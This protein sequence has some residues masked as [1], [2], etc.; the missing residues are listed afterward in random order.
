MTEQKLG[1]FE[2]WGVSKPA[3]GQVYQTYV[4]D[5]RLVAVRIGGQMDGGRAM[6]AHFGLLGALVGY[7]LQ[8][9]VQKKRAALRQAN[10]DRSLDELLLQDPKN[11]EVR[12][13][14]LE[15]AELKKGGFFKGG[16]VSLFC[17]PVGQKPIELRFQTKDAV[18]AARPVLEQA[19]PSLQTDPKLR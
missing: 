10:E 4:S 17:T 1:S 9:N 15:R 12:F 8:K 3:A 14:S 2:V 13:D 18:S 5:Q 16:R 19:M 7:F 11:F 6:T